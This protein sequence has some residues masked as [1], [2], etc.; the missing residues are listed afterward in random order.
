MQKYVYLCKYRKTPSDTFFFRISNT[1]I[2]NILVCYVYLKK[3]E[4]VY[5]IF[6]N[7]LRYYHLEK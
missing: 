6:D 3:K 1:K 5:I 7:I 4:Y 2:L